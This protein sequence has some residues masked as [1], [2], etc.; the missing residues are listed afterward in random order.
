MGGLSQAGL[1]PYTEH[2]L[3]LI[4]SLGEEP[5]GLM[6]SFVVCVSSCIT[7][8]CNCNKDLQKLAFCCGQSSEVVPNLHP[9]ISL[10]QE[11][12]GGA[13]KDSVTYMGLRENPSTRSW[14]NCHCKPWHQHDTQEPG[15]GSDML[16]GE[17]QSQAGW[18]Q[19][20]SNTG[21]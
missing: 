20:N 14:E 12:W 13:L 19:D 21:L 10:G 5:S 16:R 17:G 7:S 9:S 3:S 6:A 2:L 18:E 15:K 11:T 8:C 1:G 4:E